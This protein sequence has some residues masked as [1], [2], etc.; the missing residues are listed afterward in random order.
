MFLSFYVYKGYFWLLMTNGSVM[1]N[2]TMAYV[3]G[4]A[5][6]R[7][8]LIS[9]S[10]NKTVEGFVGG[11]IST[12]V[13]AVVMAGYFADNPQIYCEQLDITLWPFQTL[14]CERPSIYE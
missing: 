7:T 2:D 3:F 14:T 10:P 12:I 5:F 11:G 6:G 9:L 13:F 4:K 8:K 1:I